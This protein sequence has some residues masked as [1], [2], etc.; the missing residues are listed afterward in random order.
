M[1]R[2]FL[3]NVS[4]SAPTLPVGAVKGYPQDS[5]VAT[6]KLP[7]IVG[8]YALWQ[9]FQE[10]LNVVTE[11]GGTPDP[12]NLTQVAAAVQAMAN[13]A[14]QAAQAAAVAAAASDATSKANGAISTAAAD[15]T[16]KANAALDAA[17][18]EFTGSN[19]TIS[20]NGHQYWP[21]VGGV[22]RLDQWMEIAVASAASTF[23]TITY[24]IAYTHSANEPRVSAKNPN[25]SSPSANNFVGVTVVSSSL[26][27]CVVAI[28]AI[29]AGGPNVVLL[30]DVK[31]QV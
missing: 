2:Y 20:G 10:L 3:A 24:P 18:A 26:T 4:T 19:L 22:Q 30:L 11:G 21:S 29:N 16:A 15:A 25:A 23:Q 1:D 13:A 17:N 6:N 7:T 9:I 8:A 28:G 5:D 12:E 31:G 27:G 14:A